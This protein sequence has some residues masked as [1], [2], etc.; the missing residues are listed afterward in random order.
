MQLFLPATHEPL[1]HSLFL[2]PFRRLIPTAQQQE[3][4][5]D[6]RRLVTFCHGVKGNLFRDAQTFAI[7]VIGPLG[8]EPGRHGTD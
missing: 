7:E 1:T 6:F 2:E 4:L 5:A 3:A 8:V